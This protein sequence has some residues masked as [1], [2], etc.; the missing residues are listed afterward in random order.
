MDGISFAKGLTEFLPFFMELI[1]DALDIGPV[2][3]GLGRFFQ[4]LICSQERRQS[5]N[6]AVQQVIMLLAL[7]ALL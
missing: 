5:V 1:P 6:D 3:T 7:F 2:E 4:K